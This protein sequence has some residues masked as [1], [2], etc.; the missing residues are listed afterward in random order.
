MVK[1]NGGDLISNKTKYRSVLND[2]WVSMPTQAILQNTTF[3]MKITN[4]QGR[5]GYE[6]CRYLNLSIQS[7]DAKNTMKEIVNMVRLN[8][9]S[10]H[11]TIRLGNGERI[12]FRLNH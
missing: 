10:I 12:Q 6:W 3:N 7:K 5:A 11:I 9:Y 8:G 1:T 4:E 2:I